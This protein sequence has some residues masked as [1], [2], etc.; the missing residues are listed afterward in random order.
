MAA[1]IVGLLAFGVGL[2]SLLV[3]A[4]LPATGRRTPAMATPRTIIETL[5]Q[6]IDPGTALE[7]VTHAVNLGPHTLTYRRTEGGDGLI[8]IARPFLPRNEAILVTAIGALA[9]DAWAAPLLGIVPTRDAGEIVMETDGYRYRA[10]T[11]TQ[12]S[13]EVHTLRL[14][15][16]K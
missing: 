16:V 10:F 13:G 2:L 15:R 5:A 8:A 9:E 4:Q 12:E 3:W 11:A 1:R 14:R 7:S 6:E